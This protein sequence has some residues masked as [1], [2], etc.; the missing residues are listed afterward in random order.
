MT[1]KDI[2]DNSKNIAV[3]C[4]RLTELAGNY[5][6]LQKNYQVLND[7]HTD[8]ELGFVKMQTEWET[9]KKLIGWLAGGSAISLVLA[10][11]QILKIFG[12][13]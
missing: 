11:I 1:E 3:I 7:S 5:K 13:I 6:A 10:I 2:H 12:V 4:E 8:L 9:S